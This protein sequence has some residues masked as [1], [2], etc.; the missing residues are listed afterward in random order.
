MT[1]TLLLKK[2]FPP[3]LPPWQRSLGWN[4]TRNSGS[5]RCW[6]SRGMISWSMICQ[7]WKNLI[8]TG[9]KIQITAS[10][11]IRIKNQP[12][13][14]E[15]GWGLNVFQRCATR[16]DNCCCSSISPPSWTSPHFSPESPSLSICL[17]FT[18]LYIIESHHFNVI[19]FQIV[20]NVHNL[21]QFLDLC[22]S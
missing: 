6:R 22:F 2:S 9:N 18:I 14:A 17:L 15:V 4:S 19:F 20:L 7:N 8:V 16:F 12:P 5:T 11:T 3:L 21:N 10:Q 1:K 13:V